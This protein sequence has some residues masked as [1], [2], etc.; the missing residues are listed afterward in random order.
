MTTI[1][2]FAA[3]A[4]IGALLTLVIPAGK[5]SG[6]YEKPTEADFQLLLA[7]RGLM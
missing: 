5:T 1:F 3:F 2:V 4:M 7:K 6:K